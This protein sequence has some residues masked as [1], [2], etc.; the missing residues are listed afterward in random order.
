MAFHFEAAYGTKSIENKFVAKCVLIPTWQRQPYQ[1]ID[2]NSFYCY[3]FMHV[4][5]GK[6]RSSPGAVEKYLTPHLWQY[7]EDENWPCDWRL[8]V[9]HAIG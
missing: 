1:C 9:R 2:L 6:F 7:F 4:D 3:C 8:P 5:V